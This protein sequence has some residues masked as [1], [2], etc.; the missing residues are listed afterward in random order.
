MNELHAAF[1]ALAGPGAVVPAEP[2]CRIWYHEY[3]QGTPT[4]CT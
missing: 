4:D 3:D 2:D 1:C